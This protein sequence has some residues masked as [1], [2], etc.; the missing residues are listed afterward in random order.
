[1]SE[2]SSGESRNSK[3]GSTA[4]VAVASALLVAACSNGG[5][6]DATSPGDAPHSTAINSSTPPQLTER[7]E[8]VEKGYDVSWPQCGVALPTAGAFAIVGVN[9]NLPSELNPCYDQQAEWAKQSTGDADAPAFSAYVTAASPGNITPRWPNKGVNKYGECAGDNTP[10]CAYEY[11]VLNATQDLD[12]MSRNKPTR[13]WIDVE[14]EYS[15]DLG[16]DLNKATLDAMGQTFQAA[17]MEVGVYSRPDIWQTVTGGLDKGHS[18][19]DA[20][21]WLMGGI[22]AEDA[23]ARCATLSFTAGEVVMVQVPAEV[24]GT[25]VDENFK[26]P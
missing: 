18:L 14:P 4:A 7:A 15:W 17:G 20:N 3:R 11:G 5:S 1:M 24:G 6:V 23:V 13:V 22:S 25:Q 8:A 26:C 21:V 12:H 19:A 2:K 10:A 9:G 16:R